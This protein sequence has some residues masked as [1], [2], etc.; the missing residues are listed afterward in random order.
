MS[1]GVGGLFLVR[2]ELVARDIA[3]AMSRRQLLYTPARWRWIM[4][5]V[6]NIPSVV[7]RRMNF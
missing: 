6:R 7:F 1:K 4:L 2:P 3:W 5:V